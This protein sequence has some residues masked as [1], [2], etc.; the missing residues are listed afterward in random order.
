MYPLFIQVFSVQMDTT[1]ISTKTNH[2]SFPHLRN[3]SYSSVSC[4]FKYLTLAYHEQ[5]AT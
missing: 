5:L 2:T 1:T 4:E 3:M